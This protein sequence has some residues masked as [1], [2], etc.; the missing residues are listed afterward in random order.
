MLVGRY[1]IVGKSPAHPCTVRAHA[2][3][4]ATHVLPLLR[5]AHGPRLHVLVP[6][7]TSRRTEGAHRHVPRHQHRERLR[8]QRL[9]QQHEPHA[10]LLRLRPV[11][12]PRHHRKRKRG[13]AGQRHERLRAVGRPHVPQCV[14]RHRRRLEQA[15]DVA[16]AQHGLHR[17]RP[18]RRILLGRRR[19]STRGRQLHRRHRGLRGPHRHQHRRLPDGRAQR[20][21]HAARARRHDRRVVVARRRGA[22]RRA[23]PQPLVQRH[24]TQH[25][26]PRR[27][28]ARGRPQ[29]AARR[30]Q[31]LLR[32]RALRPAALRRRQRPDGHRGGLGARHRAVGLAGRDHGHGAA[33]PRPQVLRHDRRL[34]EVRAHVAARRPRDAGRRAGARRRQRGQHLLRHHQAARRPRAHPVDARRVHEHHGAPAVPDGVPRRPPRHVPP[35]AVPAGDGLPRRHV[36][37]VQPD[38]QHHADVHALPREHLLDGCGLGRVRALCARR[39]VRP[40]QCALPPH[41]RF[42]VE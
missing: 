30:H 37:L 33:V 20:Q 19:R 40:R 16:R 36:V 15:A 9:L 8:E 13:S 39:R 27:G 12:L 38:R 29:D 21:A 3:R 32:G 26:P 28:P 24:R 31:V 17:A 2:R 41:R 42:G 5:H 18:R 4:H 10:E 23:L 14:L 1:H 6:Q 25:R 35:H 7:R 22:H 34:R 11:R